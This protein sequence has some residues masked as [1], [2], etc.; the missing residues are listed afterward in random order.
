[1]PWFRA[2]LY[3]WDLCCHQ[4]DISCV[5]SKT[6]L[7]FQTGNGSKIARMVPILMFFWQNRSRRPDLVFRKFLRRRNFFVSSMSSSSSTKGESPFSRA[8]RCR[9][10][11]CLK[12]D[13]EQHLRM[14]SHV[15][16]CFFIG[17][18][19]HQKTVRYIAI[20]RQHPPR[21]RTHHP[22]APDDGSLILS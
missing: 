2:M 1:M 13:D 21:T 19:S 10:R 22:D 17:G 15:A 20:I 4:Q 5:P 7:V 6:F 3:I 16:C 18:S 14:I 9:R 11:L 8:R 12:P